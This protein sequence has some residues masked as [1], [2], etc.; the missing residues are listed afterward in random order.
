ML[1]SKPT[2]TQ[3]AKA[4][5]G[6]IK[7]GASTQK[8][9][10]QL[11]AYLLVEHRTDELAPLMRD[12]MDI[13]SNQ[14]VVEAFVTSSY[15]LESSVKEAIKELA[16]KSYPSTKQ[17]ILHEQLDQALVGGILL[18]SGEREADFSIHGRLRKLTVTNN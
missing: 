15:T 18:E 10:T 16:A 14:G 5:V 8:L 9:S 4:V 3:I 2:R 17:V 1:M 13:R 7:Q 11:A 12:I 6:L